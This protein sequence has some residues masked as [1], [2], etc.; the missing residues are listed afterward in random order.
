M[1]KVTISFPQIVVER[2]EVEVTDEQ[3]EDLTQH[4]CDSEKADFIWNNMTEQEQQ[5]TQGKK[6]LEGA[7]DAGYCGL[8]K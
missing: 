6:W 5:W 2:R 1:K 8:A 7:I 4:S 3:F